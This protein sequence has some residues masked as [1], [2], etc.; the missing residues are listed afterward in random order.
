[1]KRN[2]SMLLQAATLLA[3]IGLSG[4]YITQNRKENFAH[5]SRIL[6]QVAIENIS[7]ATVE[8]VLI[9]SNVYTRLQ[10]MNQEELNELN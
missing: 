3:L 9:K 2:K 7:N 10:A 5:S 8:N 1:M 6:K 4:T